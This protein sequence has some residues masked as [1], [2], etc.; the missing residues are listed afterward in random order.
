MHHV[1]YK[2]YDYLD[3]LL[4]VGCTNNIFSR[5]MQHREKAW[6]KD[7]SKITLTHFEDR[8]EALSHEKHCQL[9]EN[10]M[11]GADQAN[12]LKKTISV[13]Y[14]SLLAKMT[15][16]WQSHKVL[17]ESGF[18]TDYYFQKLLNDGL[19]V[20]RDRTNGKPLQCREYRLRLSRIWQ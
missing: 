16:E 3:N 9:H 19:I 10:P 7:I 6:F 12:D 17:S 20:K 14:N 8:K 18:F 13:K 2:H 4:Y 11:Y 5:T 1:V 15:K